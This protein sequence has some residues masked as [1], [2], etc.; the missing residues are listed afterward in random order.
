MKQIHIF[1]LIDGLTF[2]GAETLLR[3]LAA[4]LEQRG[5]RIT[6]AYSTHGAF[7]EELE[8]KGLRLI[9]IPRL[10][11]IDPFFLYK[12]FQILKKEN[13]DVV[14]THLFKSDFHG[15]LAARLARVPVVISTLHNNDTWANNKILGY[16]YGLTS[17]WADRLIAVSPEV[18]EFHINKTKIL[19]Q[20]TMVIQNGVDVDSFSGYKEQAIKLRK[21]FGIEST[22]PLFGIVGRLM[23]Q[24]NVPMF[25]LAAKEILQSQPNARFLIVGD[26]ELREQLQQETQN[27]NLFPAVIFTGMRKDIPII[28]NALDVL[29]LSSLWEGLP[30]IL[31]EAMAS[32]LPVVSTAVDGVV[33]VAEKDVTA[34]LTPNRDASALAQ[35]CLLLASD[36]SLRDRM[37]KA[38]YDKVVKNYSLNN[39]IDKISEQY[40]ELLSAKS[41]Q[42]VSVNS[43]DQ[44][45]GV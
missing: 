1:H 2:G 37:G 15:R 27:L 5:Y 3:D 43:A 4:G 23:P 26:G 36:S 31:L 42:P 10:G 18:K 28:L 9:Q 45:N 11:L 16:I 22:A 29:V 20:K 41:S 39:M 38:G 12:I 25:L 34:F 32:S 21:D 24:K 19:P 14:H 13:P 30:V 35:A 6:V 40:L 33:G 7:V 17:I 44:D 8:K